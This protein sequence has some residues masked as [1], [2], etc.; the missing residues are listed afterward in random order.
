MDCM[1]RSWKLVALLIRLVHRLSSLLIYLQSRQWWHNLYP[2][3]LAAKTRQAALI[4]VPE[5]DDAGNDDY[6]DDDNDHDDDD[7][8]QLEEVTSLSRKHRL[9]LRANW[10]VEWHDDEDDADDDDDDNA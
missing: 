8:D 2:Y 6:D 3:S 4:K 9:V 7:D 1:R 5:D 10:G